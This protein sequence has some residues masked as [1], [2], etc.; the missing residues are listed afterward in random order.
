MAAPKGN[1]NARRGHHPR[2]QV[3]FSGTQLNAI[4]AH[5]GLYGHEDEP[6]NIREVVQ[7]FVHDALRNL[8][9]ARCFNG[10]KCHT[11]ARE[12]STSE[13]IWCEIDQHYGWYCGLCY[14]AEHLSKDEARAALAMY[15]QQQQE[16][17]E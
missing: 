3:P 16:M 4:Y 13:M 2:V 8:D 1:Q 7:Q 11:G 15:K 12:L 9:S 6:E 14:E 5:L 17:G 10:P